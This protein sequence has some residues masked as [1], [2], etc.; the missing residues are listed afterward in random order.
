MET[1]NPLRA[2]GGRAA[3]A[4]LTLTLLA[5]PSLGS[6]RHSYGRLAEAESVGRA[7]CAWIEEGFADDAGT[8]ALCGCGDLV[9]TVT[10]QAGSVDEWREVSW[11][12]EGDHVGSSSG[13]SGGGSTSGS[14]GGNASGTSASS[15]S[16]SGTSGGGTSASSTS[17]GS[18]S[19]SSTSASSTSASSTGGSGTSASSAS[20]GTSASGT[21]A[22]GTSASGGGYGQDGS[23]DGGRAWVA[24]YIPWLLIALGILVLAALF[25]ALKRSRP[26]VALPKPAYE[27]ASDYGPV[28]PGP[29]YGN[30]PDKGRY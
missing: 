21:S 17:G 30:A 1:G 12:D 7:G 24:K 11:E 2:R 15:T 3:V 25:L 10:E 4:A 18:S 8:R 28:P 16:A 19:A 26:A 20:G 6:A 23:G 9:V 22:S 14:S 29:D 5:W 27:P 13:G